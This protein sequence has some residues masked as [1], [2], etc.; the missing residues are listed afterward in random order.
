MRGINSSPVPRPERLRDE[1]LP[2]EAECEVAARSRLLFRFKPKFAST[3]RSQS[4]SEAHLLVCGPVRIAQ[5]RKRVTEAWCVKQRAKIQGQLDK[6]GDI[7][8]TACCDSLAMAWDFTGR[9]QVGV[10]W[11]ASRNHASPRA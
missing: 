1:I 6:L 2:G 4:V 3:K 7:A 9:P 10:A 11:Q 5:H 8:L